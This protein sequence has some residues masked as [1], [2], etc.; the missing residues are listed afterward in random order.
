MRT[1][2]EVFASSRKKGKN[3]AS[4]SG[5][6]NRLGRC[7]EPSRGRKD[8]LEAGGHELWVTSLCVVCL[9]LL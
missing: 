4:E 9:Q 8:A 5:R 1:G 7:S 3:A 6:M 2:K